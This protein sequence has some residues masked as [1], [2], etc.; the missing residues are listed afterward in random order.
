MKR[1]IPAL[2]LSTLLSP[3]WAADIR[4]KHSDYG[5][6]TCKMYLD[7]VL[8]MNGRKESDPI[9]AQFTRAWG[10][11]AGYLTAYNTNVPDTYDIIGERSVG[12]Q[13]AVDTYCKEHP[14]HNFAQL[15]NSRTKE[16]YFLRLRQ[17]ASAYSAN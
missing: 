13:L 10:W 15:M 4:G 7:S 14:G 3:A 9:D 11:I 2:L 5:V 1:L 16:L 12:V 8:R 17:P 6:P